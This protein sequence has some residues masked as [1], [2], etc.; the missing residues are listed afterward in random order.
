MD[1]SDGERAEGREV[2]GKVERR[3]R[4]RLGGWMVGWMEMGWIFGLKDSWVKSTVNNY[5]Q[6]HLRPH[7]K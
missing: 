7:L 4:D 5:G 1:G 2:R 3:E 6:D